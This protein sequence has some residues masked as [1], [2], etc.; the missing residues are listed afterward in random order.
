MSLPTGLNQLT[1]VWQLCID[2]P[3]DLGHLYHPR[4]DA[5][6]GYVKTRDRSEAVTRAHAPITEYR[7]TFD[8][9]RA[10]ETLRGAPFVVPLTPEL[11]T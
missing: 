8:Q 3:V 1:G 6:R 11:K 9:Q 10:A 5:F 7:N 4:I 2:V